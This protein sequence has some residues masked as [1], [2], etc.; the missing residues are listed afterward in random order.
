MRKV[1]VTREAWLDI[2]DAQEATLAKFGQRKLIDVLR[3]L[4]DAM[5]FG[6]NI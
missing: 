4:H 6:R 5:D 1:N 3:F 2:E